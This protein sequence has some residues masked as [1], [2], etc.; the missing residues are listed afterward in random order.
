MAEAKEVKSKKVKEVSENIEQEVNSEVLATE[1]NEKEPKTLAKAGKRS[2]KAVAEKEADQAKKNRKSESNVE[3]KPQHKAPRSK[4]ERAGKK[5]R[6]VV[7]IID[8]SKSYSLPEA[9]DLT[10]KTSTTKFDSSVEL[11]IKL[12]VDPKQADQNIR[13]NVVLPA[14]SGKT[15]RIAVLCDVDDEKSAISAGAD[16]VGA[17]KVFEML[18]KEKFDFDM[19]VA[20]P[21]QMAKLGKY[22]RV[23]G[24]RGLMPS[25]KAGTVNAD[26]ARAV[27]D[28]KAGKVEYRVDSSGIIH[29]A[30]GKASFSADQLTQNAE[31][32]I[33]AVKAAKPASS[34]GIYIQ[35]IF[36]TTTMGPSVRVSL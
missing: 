32:V 2:A 25:P 3:V 14:G 20:S 4:A 28:A 5:Y 36:V 15:I 17:D 13:G 16:I 8:R 9:L 29:L 10:S 27:K 33:N 22:A 1:T 12:G 34:K 6:E 18:D 30:I 11:H 19:L 21:T 26:V 23:L 7:K 24:P 31:A 35:T